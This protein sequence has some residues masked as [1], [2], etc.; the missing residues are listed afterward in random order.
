MAL[1]RLDP[2]NYAPARCDAA[3]QCWSIRGPPDL[4][5]VRLLLGHIKLDSTLRPLGFEVND[6]PAM[7]EQIEG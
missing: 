4:R 1:I 3:W 2:E 5:A 7:A 6:A